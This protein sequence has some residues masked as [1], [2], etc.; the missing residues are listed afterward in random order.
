MADA[1]HPNAAHGAHEHHG[2]VAHHFETAE[3]QFDSSK[4]GMWLFLA[5]EVLL[6]GG[7]F[8]AYAVWR[9]N[10]PDIFV[11]GQHHLNWR[12]G[13]LNTVILLL[14]SFT[15]AWAVTCAQRGNQA[16][17][18]LGLALTFLGGVGFMVIKTIEY[19]E[20][21]DHGLLWGKKY[22]PKHHDSADEG[23]EA[24]SR[25]FGNP[26]I[27][28]SLQ[29][30]AAHAAEPQVDHN[31]NASHSNP[32]PNDHDATSPVQSDAHAVTTPAHGTE[33]A[34]QFAGVDY[35]GVK[36]PGPIETGFY[37][38]L[39]VKEPDIERLAMEPTKIFA[40]SA[41][42]TGLAPIVTADP[43]DPK[44]VRTYFSIYFCMT[45]LHGIHV[46]L[47]MGVIG[48]LLWRANRGDFSAG[49]FTPVDLGGLYWHLVDL[50]WIYLFPLL[51]LI[52]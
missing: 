34:A 11:A 44:A 31:E 4:L 48:W 18:K 52:G 42:P 33:T 20:K 24:H 5:T 51:Y 50:I 15:M 7:L 47:G 14:S 30:G 32:Q 43:P 12:L 38:P 36:G 27:A 41:A 39:G 35:H 10:H 28:A 17:L 8:C 9:A 2:H 29:D 16:G 37:L 3:Q 1:V 49:Y 46:L 13:A 6:F 19:K 22:A 23:G 25:I 26:V 40:A 21:Y 45:G